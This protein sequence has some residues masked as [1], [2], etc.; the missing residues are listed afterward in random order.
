MLA[1]ILTILLNA[2]VVF[3]VARLTPGVRVASYATAIGVAAVY[4]LLHAA[5]HGILTFIAFPLVILTLGLFLLVINGFLLWLTDKLISN[6]EIRGFGPLAVATVLITI[7]S[8]V[9]SWMV[10][11]VT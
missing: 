9:T 2:L 11:W 3:A 4:G 6:F 5:L 10:R 1:I 8:T 7:G